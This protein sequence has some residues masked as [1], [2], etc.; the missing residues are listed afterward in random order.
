[1]KVNVEVPKSQIDKA[2]N[3]KLKELKEENE[4]LKYQIEQIRKH[5]DY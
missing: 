1:M 3:E 5:V 4:R 2:L